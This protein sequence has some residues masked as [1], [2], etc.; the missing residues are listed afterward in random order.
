MFAAE[1]PKVYVFQQKSDVSPKATHFFRALSFCAR[2]RNWQPVIYRGDLCSHKL[3]LSFI[4]THIIDKNFSLA[5]F[6]DSGFAI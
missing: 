1:K 6:P 3:P 5:D 4:P 2:G